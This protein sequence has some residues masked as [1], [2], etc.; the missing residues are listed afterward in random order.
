L[1]ARLAAYEAIPEAQA[2][3]RISKLRFA[4]QLPGRKTEANSIV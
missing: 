4:T 2:R 1:F 3:E